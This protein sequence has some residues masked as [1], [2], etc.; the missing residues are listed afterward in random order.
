MIFLRLMVVL[1]VVGMGMAR[2]LEAATVTT[3]ATA[4]PVEGQGQGTRLTWEECVRLATAHNPDLEG[5]REGV[6]NSDAVR[7]GA[8]S[9]LYPQ[10]TAS[11]GDT[12]SY[13]GHTL[14]A[15]SNY[16]TAYGAQLSISQMIFNGFA[17]K[18]NIDQ[19]R[20]Q[21]ALAF[22]NLN[23]EKASISFDLK[24]AFAQ[25][26]YAQ[27]L[28]DLSRNVIDIRQN[29]ARLV[30]LLYE[31]GNE[32]KGAM[33]LSQAN[34]DQA[35]FNLDQAVRTCDLSGI[36]LAVVIGQDLPA[37]IQGVGELKT[38][39]LP[40]KPDFRKLAVL[41]PAYFQKQ[42]QADAAAAGITLAQSGFYPTISASAS[43]ALAEAQFPP[44]NRSWSTGFTVSYPI[45]EG[46]Q[47]YFD[48]KA[49]RASLRQALAGLRSGT[50]QA[51]LTLAQTFK[52]LVDA[53][54]NV[55]IQEELLDATALRYKIAEARYRN[56][57]MSFQDF[58]TIIDSYVAQQ[59]TY[60]TSQ[61]DAVIA[62]ANW[63][64]VKGFGAIP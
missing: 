12:R 4:T 7:M 42:A 21:L 35:T 31:G 58:D 59:T 62:E 52:A 15:P 41:T 19:A 9:T 2:A 43:G 53:E 56:G 32:D 14:S 28:I 61:R 63:E 22:A 8:Y 40:A 60:L 30:K 1:L 45:F 20:A 51:A 54:D 33:L 37:P 5:S 23:A 24:S 34:L 36:Q 44:Q 16:S 29:T 26:L 39:A 64:Q 25:L 49:A 13:T 6:L 38:D 57:L 55:H 46:G 10:I 50:D 3:P 17:T 48:V 47:T 27:Q 11:F 18:G